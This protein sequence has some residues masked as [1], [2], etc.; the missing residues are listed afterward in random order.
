LNRKYMIEVSHLTKHFGAHTA[1]ED[2]S[3]IVGDGEICGFL[4]PNGAGKSTALAMLTGCLAPSGGM[5]RIAG[6]DLQKEPERAKAMIGYL[7]ETPPLYDDMTVRE[8]LDFAARLRR[9]PKAERTAERERVT[10]R[11]A[12]TGVENRLIRNLSKGYRQRCG[13]AQ[14]LIGNPKVL[15]FDEPAAGLDPEQMKNLRELLLEQKEEHTVLI[16]SH[17][18][19]EAAGVC[20]TLLILAEGRLAASGSPETIL[21]EFG[22]ESLVKEARLCTDDTARAALVQKGLTSV[23]L[24]LTGGNT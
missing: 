13:F 23:F 7:P 19:A 1:V 4:G 18:L 24:K 5:I 2:L 3:F 14:A 9:V 8:Y 16:S 10:Q 20:D 6:T 15:V 21:C 11:L 12:L 22:E 17:N